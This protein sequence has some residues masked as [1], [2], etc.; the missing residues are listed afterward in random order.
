M[1]RLLPVRSP[2]AGAAV[3]RRGAAELD[4]RLRRQE[5]LGAA[6][7]LVAAR[8]L[9]RIAPRS[10]GGGLIGLLPL[11]A[12][13]RFA[14]GGQGERPG[15]MAA[16]ELHQRRHPLIDRRMG[17]EDVG[18]PYARIVDA[19]FPAGGGRSRELAGTIDLADA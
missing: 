17:V 15:V 10:G 3:L 1:S 18:G 4:R 9:R 7:R 2:R 8:R 19:S 11:F 14:G 5:R 12:R 13:V 16:R 6:L